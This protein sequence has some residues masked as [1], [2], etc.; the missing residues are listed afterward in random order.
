MSNAL[1][2]F[3]NGYDRNNK[4]DT[5]RHKMKVWHFFLVV[6]IFCSALNKAQA[7][8]VSTSFEGINQSTIVI[9][10]SPIT[11]TFT[12]GLSQ[13]VGNGALY[14]S[15]NYSWHIGVNNTGT[16]NFE[17]NA[18][19]VEFWFRDA[20][21]A[22]SS[23]IRIYDEGNMVLLTANGTQTYA[24]VS[25]TR[26]MGQTLIARIEVQNM[27]GA[28][29]VVDDFS[30]SG[31]LPATGFDPDNPV[32]AAIAAGTID[33]DLVPLAS[34][35]VA[36]NWG[37]FAPGDSSSLYVADQV[38]RIVKVDLSGAGSQLFHDLS[39][40]LVT[41]GIAGPD[42]FDER[43][44]LGLAF[45]PD[46]ANNG[47]FYTYTSEPVSGTADFTTLMPAEVADHQSVILEWT[48]TSPNTI[49]ASVNPVAR[50]LLRIDQ[51]QF[52]HNG[53]ALSFDT[54]NFLYI[55]LGDGGNADDEGSGHGANGNGRDALNIL[56]SLLRID[57][58]GNNATNGNYG[59]PGSN[60]FIGSAEIDEIFAYGLRNPFRFSF[61]IAN[62]SLWLADVGQNAIEEIN[63]PMAGDNLGWNH[64]EGSFFFSG[65]GGGSGTVSD[66]DP[67][68]PA[69][70]IDPVAQYDHDEGTAII[71]GFVYRGNAVPDLAGR[72]VFGDYG[73]T[74]GS[75]GRL[76][77]LNASN[78]IRELDRA[79]SFT[80]F[81]LGWGQDANGE[82]YLL[83][84]ATGIP[85]GSSGIVYRVSPPLTNPGNDEGGDSPAAFAL[86][87]PADGTTGLGT[88]IT[89]VWQVATDP[90]GDLLTYQFFLCEDPGFVGC[91]PTVVAA[92]E[93]I[94]DYA[95]AEGRLP[96]VLFG[97]L[98]GGII[99]L[100][101]RKWLMMAVVSLAIIGLVSSCGGG[102]GGGGPAPTPE[103][104]HTVAGLKPATTYFWKVSVSDGINTVES[105][106][107]SF[108][109][110]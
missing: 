100:R 13:T 45:H 69:G 26:N 47:L 59:V 104:S 78:D 58:L 106:T 51:P 43:G 89:F 60:P 46:F 80:D 92:A 36:P 82:I 52:N 53:G 18:N 66:I 65:N 8:D 27:G 35:L 72:Y 96:L 85:F 32:P 11:A 33:V 41:L 62:G 57:P 20:P 21:G 98:I 5:G 40:R 71:G 16:V 54:S 31:D 7:V 90:N 83:A 2:V 37:T 109:T 103:M 63:Q 79:D 87:S 12:G 73:G 76:F 38:G 108:S 24:M 17:S 95:A 70:L 77:Y 3:N 29:T 15:G 99:G 44:L 88:T 30:F 4:A 91:T 28:D 101:R 23:E 39:A 110:L 49:M 74:N 93:K 48:V 86:V 102:G 50:E 81:V 34:G 25:L 9:G 94:I 61:D 1:L 68:V 56:G 67:G 64:K 19:S 55:A 22:A 10:S 42:S 107:R 14:H 105:T 97:T 6:L 84:N 75:N